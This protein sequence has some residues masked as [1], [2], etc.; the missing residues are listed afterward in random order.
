[1]RW[2]F[3]SGGTSA[4]A[5]VFSMNIQDWFSLGLTGWISLQSKGLSRVFSNTTVEKHQFFG[6][7]PSLW[8]NVHIHTC[9]LKTIA[10]SPKTFVGKVMHLLFNLLS[11]FVISFSSK[12]EVSFNFM[13][14]LIICSDF[15]IQ[16]SK[17][18]RC[19][20]FSLSIYHEVMGPDA[21]SL[22]FEYSV[23][24]QL[25]HSPLLPSSRCSLV[26]LCFLP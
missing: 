24:S 2:L 12:E 18:Y 23:L 20:H 26:S 25:F 14:A 1:M 5:S 10:L 9:L 19:L 22:F 7:Q 21:M 16:E 8:S 13:S 17:V 11:R 6:A 3:T 15:G 4:S